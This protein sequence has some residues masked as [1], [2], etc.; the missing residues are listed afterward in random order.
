MNYRPS[1]AGVWYPQDTAVL[2]R[3]IEGYLAAA[4][5]VEVDSEAV[6]A[7]IVP[8]AGI[9]YS[10]QTAAY[11]YATL[12]QARPQSVVILGPLHHHHPAGF[13]TSAHDAYLTPLGPVPVDRRLVDRISSC[14]AEEAGVSLEPLTVEKEHSIELQLPFLQSVLG[15]FRFVPIMLSDQ[16]P[17]AAQALARALRQAELGTKSLLVASSDLT[18]FYPQREAESLDREMIDRML[19]LD[20]SAVLSAQ[21]QGVGFACGSGAIAAALWQAQ[22]AGADAGSLLRYSTSGDVTGD[23]DSVVGYA[24]ICVYQS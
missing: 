22:E 8:H 16:S 7:L 12:R 6:R 10:G 5:G 3:T 23:F 15:Q 24:A 14:L 21:E 4:T 9:Q 11:G 20:A 19:H 17:A 13:L 1:I 18:H 2:K